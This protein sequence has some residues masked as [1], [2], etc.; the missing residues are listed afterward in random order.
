[1]ISLNGA[2]PTRAQRNRKVYKYLSTNL[3]MAKGLLKKIAA[4][5]VMAASALSGTAKSEIIPINS[6]RDLYQ[7]GDSRTLSSVYSPVVENVMY[8]TNH[9]DPSSDIVLPKSGYYD[10]TTKTWKGERWDGGFFQSG[11]GSVAGYFNNNNGTSNRYPGYEGF[12]TGKL[13]ATIIGEGNRPDYAFLVHDVLGDG[14]GNYDS[15]TG[16]LN[17]SGADGEVYTEMDIL[18]GQKQ[19]RGDVSN[20]PTVGP[21]TRYLSKLVVSGKQIGDATYYNGIRD[22]KIG[23][24]GNWT[25]YSDLEDLAIM[26]ENWMKT[27][28]SPQNHWAKGS[29]YNTDGKVDF[30]DYALM[31][32]KF[33]P[34]SAM[35]YTAAAES[36]PKEI[37]LDPSKISSSV[38]SNFESSTQQRNVLHL[39]DKVADPNSSIYQITD[40]VF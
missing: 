17:L 2:T 40:I 22:G 12:M 29:D 25:Q 37:T 5:V 26:T 19:L 18:F 8:R 4:G 38:Q 24:D 10:P 21:G 20:L 35:S 16:T 34:G 23:S 27:D 15:S 14:I 13:S 28:S 11:S 36:S 31:A 39:S 33:L 1:M 6:F 3:N 30:A 9:D 7:K 32:S